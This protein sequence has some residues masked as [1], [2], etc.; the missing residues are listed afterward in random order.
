MSD[1]RG[2]FGEVA[3][4]LAIESTQSVSQAM[5]ERDACTVEHFGDVRGDYTG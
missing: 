1:Q 5:C 2:F 4:Q 3:A